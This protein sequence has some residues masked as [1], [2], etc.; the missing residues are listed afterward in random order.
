MA[1]Q[2]TRWGKI[3]DDYF[4]FAK[5]QRRAVVIFLAGIVVLVLV[6]AIWHFFAGTTTEKASEVLLTEVT[7]LK[8][9]EEASPWDA[10]R[11]EKPTYASYREADSESYNTKSPAELFAFDPNTVTIGDWKRLGLREKTAVTIQKYLAKG[12]HFY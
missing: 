5:F 6:P 8:A 4:T 9:K 7:Q 1:K 2:H 3:V 10:N 11:Q 12:G